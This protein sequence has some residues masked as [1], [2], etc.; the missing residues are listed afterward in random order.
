M[1][2]WKADPNVAAARRN[3]IV[4]AGNS[5][6]ALR[7]AASGR[8]MKGEEEH[9]DELFIQSLDALCAAVAAS[10][11][12]PSP[13]KIVSSDAWSRWRLIDDK[14]E[15][16]EGGGEWHRATLHLGSK[17]SGYTVTTGTEQICKHHLEAWAKLAG[18]SAGSTGAPLAQ[19]TPE[20]TT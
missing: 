6:N 9:Y 15:T 5:A 4:A 7:L 20:E 17:Q 11:S 16:S 13:E 2:N 18:A 12:P 3:A 1:T 8:A 14:L 19:P 10:G